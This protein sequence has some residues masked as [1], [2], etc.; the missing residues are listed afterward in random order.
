[1]ISSLLHHFTVPRVVRRI[2]RPL[3]IRDLKGR[4]TL[5]NTTPGTRGVVVIVVFVAVLVTEAE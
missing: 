1:M 3:A 2:D 5:F 4:T